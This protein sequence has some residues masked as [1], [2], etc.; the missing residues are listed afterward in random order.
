[1][2][3]RRLRLTA[4]PSAI[5]PASS[6]SPCAARV[7]PALL[8]LAA[9]TDDVSSPFLQALQGEWRVVYPL[10]FKGNSIHAHLVLVA[11]VF[12]AVHPLLWRHAHTCLSHGR[13]ARLM[14]SQGASGH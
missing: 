4:G 5:A 8:R 10:R 12:R 13:V 6:A 2:L 7:P 1:M 14:S 3:L 11:A 9:S